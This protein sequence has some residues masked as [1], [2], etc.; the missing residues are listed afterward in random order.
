MT[1]PA[2]AE[3]LDSKGTD[4]WLTFPQNSYGSQAAF[5]FFLSASTDRTINIEIPGL[6]FSDSV[7]VS[8]NVTTKYDLPNTVEVLLK[9]TATNQGIHVTADDEFTV[10]GLSRLQYSTDAYLG[11][12]T[13]VAGSN[14]T[15]LAWDSGLLG[16]SQYTLVGTTDNTTLSITPSAT[17]PCGT[18]MEV[19]LNAGD[20]YQHTS[21]NQGDVTGTQI[22]ASSAISVFAGHECANIPDEHHTAC[23][24]I[25]EQLPSNDTWGQRF[26]VTPLATRTNGD[27]F[28]ILASVNE[29]TV[30]VAGIE[31][32]TL[33]AGEFYEAIITEAGTIESNQPIL[34]AQY[35]NGSSF[36]NVASDPFMMLIPPYEQF[37]DDYTFATPTEGFKANYV[38]I[39]VKNSLQSALL[40]DGSVLDTA[41]FKPIAG[42]DFS[43]AQVELLPGSHTLTGAVAGIFVYGY[44]F[45]DSYGYAGGLSLSEVALVD[46]VDLLPNFSLV[47][48]EVCFK[49]RV[50]D[51]L[52][53]ALADIRVDFIVELIEGSERTDETGIATFCVEAGDSPDQFN[54]TATVGGVTTE[55]TVVEPAPPVDPVDPVDPRSTG[56]EVVPDAPNT[57]GGK[58]GGSSSIPGLIFLGFLAALRR[59]FGN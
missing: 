45:Y 24:H 23:D 17:D 57:D 51:V 22:Q 53:A 49:A 15:L 36:D 12:P 59:R 21:C 7:D 4:F 8:A 33:A 38:N 50:S 29:T 1:L 31:V 13:N 58:S 48:D 46:S 26:L 11:L 10:Y 28:R 56:D 18:A 39:V 55:T 35:S 20:V 30:N 44:H 34:V 19:T 37:L 14:Y 43:F 52:D 32:A 54:V 40:L 42:S 25:I 2:A 5:S 9:D 3:S 16:N 41:N 6:G 47:E 27:T